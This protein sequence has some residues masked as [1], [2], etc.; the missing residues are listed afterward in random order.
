MS[1]E[2]LPHMSVREGKIC[3]VPTRLFRMSFTGERGFEV[4]VPADYGQAVWEALWAEGQKHGACAYGTEAMHV[5][6]AEKGYIIVGQDT[7]G[8][9]TPNDAGLDWAV[10]K[11]KT[12]FVG[13]RGHDAARPRRQGP[14]AACRPEDQRPE[15]GAGRRRADRRRSEAADPDEDDRPCHVEL[16]VGKL[17]PLDRAGAGRR[18]PRPD[19]RDALRA[20]AERR[21]SRWRSPAWC[22]STRRESA[23]MAKAA[24][25]QIAAAPANAGRLL[26]AGAFGATGVTLAVLP[27]AERISLRAPAASVAALSKALGVSLPQKPKTSAAKAGRTA[28]WLGPDEWLVIDEAAKGPARRLRR[29]HRRCIRRSASRIATS[30]S[31]SPARRR[32]RRS[33]PAA[34]RT[35]R[36]TPFRSARPRAPSSARPRSCCCAPQTTRSAS[37][38]GARFPIMSLLS[39]RRRPSDAAA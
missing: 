9:V 16:L 28:L 1:D 2:A 13:I 11:K 25:K 3:G 32:R 7:D 18:R 5:L 33:M 23:S 24:A 36:S 17:R 14:Q 39:C 19:G 15:N 31:R 21:R 26:P 38:A 30:P 37:N 8:T 22:S 12:D 10:G 6:R 34:R 35:C 27:P 4:N 29:G 20:D